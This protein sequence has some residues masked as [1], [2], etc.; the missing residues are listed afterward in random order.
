MTEET[1]FDLEA[2][3]RR[4]GF[5]GDRVATLETLRLLQL[6][7]LDAIPFENV[8]V[9]L[10]RPIRLDLDSLQAKLV[11]SRR[12]GY[13]FEHN[14]LF[15]VVLRR[16]GFAVATL[17]ARVRPP[18]ATH[19]LPRTHMTLRVDVCG[20]AFLADVGFGGDG[21]LEPVPLD[22][23][24]SEQGTDAYRLLSE[25]RLWTLQ[26]R[27]GISWNDLYAFTLDEA[28]P[29]DFEVANHYTSTWP[30]S[31]FTKTLTAQRS[32]PG[33]RRV[34]RHRTYTVRRGVVE[35]VSEVTDAD[36]IGLLADQFGIHLPP[37]T[38]V[39]SAAPQAR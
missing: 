24:V 29:V 33:E 23:A 15:A 36:L 11:G 10:H 13:C 39:P 38:L 12:G 20:A 37:G 17:E 1:R 14:T 18:G 25:G 34:L 21:P 6:A 32:R 7:H 35:S 4:I 27:R 31:P 19:V 3:L 22:G 9:L 5:V 2:Y 8:D 30:G 16:M 28:L 26:M